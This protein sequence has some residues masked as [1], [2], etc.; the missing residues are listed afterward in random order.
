MNLKKYPFG[1][2]VWRDIFVYN[3]DITVKSKF[4]IITSFLIIFA[5]QC[6]KGADNN[7]REKIL[8]KYGSVET[9]KSFILFNAQN[10]LNQDQ[11]ATV[12]KKLFESL[13]RKVSIKQFEGKVSAGTVVSCAVSRRKSLVE[14][15]EDTP[16][17]LL[18]DASDQNQPLSMISLEQRWAIVNIHSLKKH[19]KGEELVTRTVQV[20]LRGYAS[21]LGAGYSKDV[22]SLMLPMRD[23]KDLAKMSENLEPTAIKSAYFWATQFGFESVPSPERV[24]RQKVVKG[25]V[26]PLNPERWPIWEKRFNKKVDEVFKKMGYSAAS[27]KDAYNQYIKNAVKK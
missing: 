10:N 21:I 27:V 5:L 20:L 19:Y 13:Q 15:K 12:Q 14:S 22:R 4:A 23:V 8:K 18:M 1:V 9:D 24:Y 7:V 6:V 2:L 3:E 17:V 11:L 25:E 16:F 26:P